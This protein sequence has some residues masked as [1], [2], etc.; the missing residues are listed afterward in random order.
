MT[1]ARSW[2]LTLALLGTQAV[3]VADDP[4]CG[5]ASR[6]VGRSDTDVRVNEFLKRV[7]DTMQ[8]PYKVENKSGQTT[9]WWVPRSEA[10]EK[11]VDG[12]LLQYGF[13]INGC[14]PEKWPTPDT[15]SGTLK[16][17]EESKR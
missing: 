9:I 7:L 14:P 3:A 13:A 10:E 4:Y 8:L 11:E 17:C 1:V 12:R 15:P 16:V 2:F 5:T 6:C